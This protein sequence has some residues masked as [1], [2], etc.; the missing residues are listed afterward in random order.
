MDKL[1]KKQ[2][3]LI[4]VATELF[5]AHG[6]RRIT[7]DEICRTSN[8]SKMTFY[9]YFKNKIAIAQAVLESIYAQG[10]EFYYKM[11]EEDTP[12]SIKIQNILLIS[13]SQTHAIGQPFFQDITDKSSP[14]SSFFYEKQNEIKNMTIDFCRDAQEKGCIRKDVSIDV[15]MF[16][17]NSQHEQLNHPDF[18]KSIPDIEDRCTVLA[19]LFFYGFI[20]SAQDSNSDC[21]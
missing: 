11:L 15:M 9:K 2:R 14:L 8:I 13:R 16:M 17:L 6:F 20:G 4:E 19:S 21:I 1:P 18:V 5:S 10:K 12:F 3:Q 7:I